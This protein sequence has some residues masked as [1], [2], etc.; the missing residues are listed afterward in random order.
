MGNRAKKTNTVEG[1]KGKKV[2]T[3]SDD[4]GGKSV[5]EKSKSVGEKCVSEN[6]ANM[7]KGCH[8]LGCLDHNFERSV[9]KL[10]NDVQ[11][12]E[13]FE[14]GKKVKPFF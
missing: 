13:S 11:V 10:W 2:R 8:S 4:T 12:K 7:I 1:G 6:G 3:T 9:L 5:S 14:K